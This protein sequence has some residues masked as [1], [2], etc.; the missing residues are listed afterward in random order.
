MRLFQ[1]LGLLTLLPAASFAAIN[2]SQTMVLQT[3]G[4]E[5]ARLN[6]EG[7]IAIRVSA[8]YISVTY[9]EVPTP[10]GNNQ[11]ATKSYVDTAVAAGGSGRPT[12]MGTTSSTYVGGSIG[13]MMNA[14]NVCNANYSGSRMMLISDL[15]KLNYSGATISTEGWTTCDKM[16]MDSNPRCAGVFALSSPN[17][18]SGST[19]STLW[20]STSGYAV[21]ITT[22]EVWKQ[23]ICST[24]FP[25]HC[26][27]D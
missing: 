16:T 26:V 11:P 25:I 6:T 13:S 4:T 17:C 2:A 5:R 8:T 7:I 10:T 12:Y 27:K 20:S 19:G 14:N 9:I 24:S 18:Q 1:L 23:T 3:G 22:G 15:F 21:T